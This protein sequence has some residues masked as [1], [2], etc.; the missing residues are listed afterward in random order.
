MVVC[1]PPFRHKFTTFSLFY[2]KI[3][4][5]LLSCVGKSI[6]LQREKERTMNIAIDSNIYR[7]AQIYAQSRQQSLSTI[8]E[9]YLLR[10]IHKPQTKKKTQNNAERLDAA[11]QFVKRLSAPGGQPV[12]A[13]ARGLEALLDDKYDL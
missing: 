13:E 8:V 7:Q 1:L 10:L 5:K 12:P 4:Q 2:T 6:S 3:L 9:N 11:L